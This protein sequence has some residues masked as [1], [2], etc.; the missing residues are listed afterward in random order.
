MYHCAVCNQTMKIKNKKG[1][2]TSFFHQKFLTE[3]ANKTEIK[4]IDENKDMA[5]KIVKKK[6]ADNE[7]YKYTLKQA[8]D[9]IESLKNPDSTKMIAKNSLL[10]LIYWHH[11]LNVKDE[12]NTKTN[13]ELMDDENITS[14]DIYDLLKDFDLTEKAID[15]I[16]IKKTNEPVAID[17]KKQ[18]IT[19]ITYLNQN[20]PNKI[21]LPKETWD[22]Y[23]KLFKDYQDQSNNKRRQNKVNSE[24]L[25][26]VLDAG[27]DWV[28][29][30]QMYDDFDT[31]ASYTNTKTGRKNLRAVCMVGFYVLQRP[32][33]SEDYWLLQLWTKQPTEKDKKDRNI[34][35]HEKDQST[36]YIDSF[37]TRTL[38]KNNKTK[39]V[40]NTFETIIDSRL[41]SLLKD[42]IKKMD[43]K[44]GDYI[45]P[46]ENDDLKI[47]EKYT[48]TSGFGNNLT[49][50]S[51]L[52]FKVPV[53]PNEFRH[54]FNTWLFENGNQFTDEQM[55]RFSEEVGDKPKDLPT[56]LRY[57]I[58]NPANEG[59]TK[60]QI[61]KEQE[62]V[63]IA[64]NISA[65]EGDSIGNVPQQDKNEV[66]NDVDTDDN[67]KLLD[68]LWS[69][70]KPVLLRMM[71]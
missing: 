64:G 65:D 22:K 50:A 48:T 52:I 9:F 17:T 34:L 38:T 20:L 12:Y 25:Q 46:Q 54:L 1:H 19:A 69:A 53:G 51:K 24:K 37:K 57:R 5:R 55:L 60:T 31:K 68:N 29:L 4:Y 61:Q 66:I 26:K 45:F 13:K 67:S 3:F 39:N 33:R 62:F 41:H 16:K 42:F 71:L 70:L 10:N 32:R 49:S 36:L 18:V 8:M 28:K 47:N 2:E 30:K 6:V 35:Y 43:Y 59:K 63:Q 58:A 14:I 44:Q 27:I 40:L 15:N 56:N 11:N 7:P 23:G 21:D